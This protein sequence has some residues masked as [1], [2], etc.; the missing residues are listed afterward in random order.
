MVGVRR[1]QCRVSKVSFLFSLVRS[2]FKPPDG[3]HVIGV[4]SQGKGTR[5]K[6]HKAEEAQGNQGTRQLDIHGSINNQVAKA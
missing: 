3:L 4:T 5:Q 1:Q 6:R 2:T